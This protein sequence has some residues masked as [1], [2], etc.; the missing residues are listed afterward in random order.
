MWRWR[1]AWAKWPVVSNPGFKGC[2]KPGARMARALSQR[3]RSG[4][5]YRQQTA[6]RVGA[7]Q[8]TSG[9]PPARRV[10][11]RRFQTR[12]A[13]ETRRFV[14]AVVSARQKQPSPYYCYWMYKT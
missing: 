6:P 14:V 8:E 13:C 5:S 11:H 10:F 7:A 4:R 2:G 9:A 3:T 1:S 12:T